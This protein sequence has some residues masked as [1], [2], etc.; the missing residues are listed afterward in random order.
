MAWQ[1]SAVPAG[2]Y[3][4]T[5]KNN[6]GPDI[7]MGAVIAVVSDVP[8][9]RGV[10]EDTNTHY[11]VCETAETPTSTL[12]WVHQPDVGRSW[13]DKPKETE[14]STASSATTANATNWVPLRK[15]GIALVTS[16]L[17]WIALQAGVDLGES[18]INEAATGL[19]GLL[20]AYIVPDPRVKS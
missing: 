11:L 18:E 15:I 6:R 19:V 13:I 7:A 5:A 9:S 4:E 16:A 2:L 3:I 10:S 14:G 20:T 12:A 17:T 8:R 1:F